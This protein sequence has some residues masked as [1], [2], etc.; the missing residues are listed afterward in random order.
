MSFASNSVHAAEL[1][2]Y[3]VAPT[4]FAEL[5]YPYTARVTRRDWEVLLDNW[6]RLQPNADRFATAFFD[7]LFACDPELRQ[8]FG[9]TSLETQF[10]KFAHLL[11]E[12]ISVQNDPQEL[13]RRV[14]MVVHRYA[15]DSSVDYDR[16]IRAAITAM[17][18]EV[19]LA[20]LTP[21]ARQWW[22]AAHGTVVSIIRKGARLSPHGRPTTLMRRA[23]HSGR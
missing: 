12:L 23:R 11:T 5:V 14:D 7:A 8:L 21:E 3:P 20:R 4:P 2:R 13:E 9:G 22:W 18:A 16:A 6:E 1:E 10:V 19:A 17:L 15:S